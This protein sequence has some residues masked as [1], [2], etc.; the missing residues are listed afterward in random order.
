M[1]LNGGDYISGWES[2]KWSMVYYILLKYKTPVQFREILGDVRNKT[3]TLL[4]WFIP[5]GSSFEVIEHFILYEFKRDIKKGSMIDEEFYSI[6]LNVQ[7]LEY[8]G[9]NWYTERKDIEPLI[10]NL[11]DKFLDDLKK[12][13]KDE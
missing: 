4:Q 1:S 11:T 6:G 5:A 10:K 9:I 3:D 13:T 7:V 2:Q 12:M 8:S